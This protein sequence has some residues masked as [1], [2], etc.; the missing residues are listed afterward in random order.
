MAGALEARGAVLDTVVTNFAFSLPTRQK[1]RGL[2]K[3]RLLRKAVEPL[4]P[5]SVVHGRKRGFSIPAA[6]WLRADLAPFARETLAPETL[7]RQGYL[8]PEPVTRM[9][10]DHSSG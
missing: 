10:D 9:L 7:R 3:K 8:Q 2:E 6:P 1:V 4:L 5:A